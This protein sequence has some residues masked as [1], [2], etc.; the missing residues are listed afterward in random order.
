MMIPTFLV[1][2]DDGI[3]SEGLAVLAAAAAQ[4]GQVFAVAPSQQCSA[5]SQRITI[6]EPLKIHSVD[7][8]VRGIPAWRVDGTPAD[9]VKV[10][11]RELLPVWPDFLLS[12][13]NHGFNTGFDIAYSGTIGAAMEGLMNG[14]PSLAFSSSHEGTLQQ[15][16]QMLPGLLDALLKKPIERSAIWNVNFPKGG[17]ERFRGVLWDRFIAPMQLY[18]DA[19]QVEPAEDG[20]I[21]MKNRGMPISVDRVPPGSDI[22]AVLNR[23]V[24][25]GK[26]YCPVLRA[27]R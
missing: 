18:L 2:N 8:P 15:A 5:M 1:V 7:F 6:F 22:H 23:Y 25:I 9:C 4:L 24:S 20:S 19:F 12:G 13:V 27:A 3:E 21:S 11:L 17:P 14:V 26:V 16:K 10:A